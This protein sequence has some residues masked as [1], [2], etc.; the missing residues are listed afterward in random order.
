MSGQ[1]LRV[2]KDLPCYFVILR[3]Q[4]LLVVEQVE[5]PKVQH[6]QPGLLQYR[7]TNAISSSSRQSLDEQRE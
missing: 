4:S 6:S 1:L 3:D 5:A 7:L 2:L